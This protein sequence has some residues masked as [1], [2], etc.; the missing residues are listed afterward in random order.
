MPQQ[1]RGQGQ[2][3]A[4]SRRRSVRA[5]RD[6]PRPPRP[7]L[8]PRLLARRGAPAGRSACGAAATSSCATATSPST[9]LFFSAVVAG[10]VLLQAFLGKDFSF[11]YVAENSDASL[12]TFYRIA[13]FWAGAAGL[14][15]A[16]AA[17]PC[18]SSP[19]SSR[20]ATSSRSTGSRPA[21]WRCSAPSPPSSPAHGLRPGS[22]PFVETA[23]GA[24]ARASTRCCCTRP[25]CCTRRRCSSAT[26]ASRCP[27]PS[28]SA[29]CCSATPAAAGCRALPEVGR[30]RLAV[31]VAG[32]RPG[33]LVGLRRAQLGRLL[34]LGPGREHLAGALAHGHRPAALVARST[35]ARGLFKRWALALACATFWCTIVAT[36]TTRTGLISSVHAF[37]QQRDAGRDPL[38]PGHRRGGR[39]RVALIAWRWRRFGRPRRAAGRGSRDLA[40][41]PH[42]PRPQRC[43]PRPCFR[44]GRRAA[45]RPD[46]HRAADLRASS[47]SRSASRS[48]WLLA[49]LS[50][51]RLARRG[52]SRLWRALRWPL[53]AAAAVAARAAADRRLARPACAA[54][55][56]S[57]SAASPPR[58]VHPVRAASARRA[59]GDA[60]SAHRPAA[61]RS[62]AAA[63]AAPPR[64][65]TSAWSSSWPG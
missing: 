4:A 25:W 10:A 61:A 50:A 29:R 57:R 62:P 30:G 65:P 22:N 49:R 51:A 28:P 38:G 32:H 23:P 56:A 8:V 16:L 58:R 24:A 40:P 9:A 39:R 48:C 53:L 13:G 37:E 11:A 12:S 18:R 64:S 33:R 2:S 6:R 54:S 21:P 34:G 17:A 20:C 27:S 7:V 19:S 47:R 44:H 43:S 59:A 63:R 15:P 1:V 46:G 41:L 35:G 3:P 42:Q 5:A 45:R 14:V 36:W 31:P 55:S 52:A 60:G 26:S